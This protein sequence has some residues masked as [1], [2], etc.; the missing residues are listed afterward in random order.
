M[1]LL[2]LKSDIINNKLDNFYCFIGEEQIVMDL[3]ISKI[4][5]LSNK[6]RAKV[7]SVSD[8]FS[9]LGINSMIGSSNCYII[10]ND[11][12]YLK[13]EKSWQDLVDGNAQGEN[14][15]VL[16]YYNLDKRGKFYKQLK[17]T[18]VEFEKMTAEV[19]AKHVIKDTGLNT[20]YAIDFANRCNCFYGIV[21]NETEKLK[22]FSKICDLEINKAYVKAVEENL[23]F[24]SPTDV[25]F[26]LI[27]SICLRAKQKTY[28]LYDEYK[29]IEDSALPLISLLYNN[30]R[31][32]LLVQSCNKDV[33]KTTG[34]TSW[35]IRNAENKVNKYSINE[36]IEALRLLQKTEQGI[37]SGRIDNV[38]AI[39]FILINVLG[40]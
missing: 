10:I 14:I 17:D 25:I 24:T 18:I 36:L 5:K 22:L 1:D 2:K 31:N 13:K 16:I 38:I 7:D 39:D 33:S 15:I 9:K 3:Y 40:G 27:D 8:I 37:K 30:F 12:E 11:F 19:I 21:L 29:H 35:Q 26:K 20:P 34:L 32:I 6:T 4:V 23:I 28:L